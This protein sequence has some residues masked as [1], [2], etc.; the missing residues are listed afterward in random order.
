MAAGSL[1]IVGRGGQ[2]AVE[3][4]L[5]SLSGDFEGERLPLAARLAS[6]LDGFFIADELGLGRAMGIDNALGGSVGKLHLVG[7]GRPMGWCGNAL[8][9][10]GGGGEES[11]RRGG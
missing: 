1:Q 10:G 9:S 5:E 7:F 11:G 2:R 4:D 6:L 8:G 3:D